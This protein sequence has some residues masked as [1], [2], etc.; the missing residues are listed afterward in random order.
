MTVRPGAA[1]Q[2]R[3]M[4]T[5]AK[6]LRRNREGQMGKRRE[7]FPA[8]LWERLSRRFFRYD[9][10]GASPDRYSALRRNIVILMMAV[11]IVPLTFMAAINHHLYQSGLRNEIVGPVQALVSKTK[12]SFELFMEERLSTIRFIASAYSFAELSDARTINRIFRTLKTEFSG[13]I[14]LGLFDSGGTQVSYAGPYAHFLGRDYSRQDWFQEV[15]VRGAYISDVFTGYREL[16]HVAIAVQ[17]AQEDGRSWILRATIDTDK[18]DA[19]IASMGMDP[20]S[21][22]FLVNRDGILQTPSRFYGK[23]LQRVPFPVPPATPTPTVAEQTDHLEHEILLASVQLGKPDYTLVVVKPRSVV[24]KSWFALKS[25]MLLVFVVSVA[26]ITLVVLKL[27]AVLVRDI[28]EADEKRESAFRELEHNQKL[29]SIGRLAAGVAHEINNP[30]AII[31]EKAGLIKDIVE[32]T[33]DCTTAGDKF[34]ALTGSILQNVQRCRAITHRLL[35]F[36][37]RLDVNVEDLN[38]NEI[39]TEVLGFLEKE[40]VYRKIKI[41]LNLAPEL[42]R[43]SSDRGQLQQ[44]FLNILNNAF[45]AVD[46]GGRVTITTRERDA[47]TLAVSVQDN[48]CGMSEETLRHIFEP[49]FTTKKEYGTGLGLP[50]TYGIVKKLGGDF[51]VESEEGVGTN[52]TVLLKKHPGEQA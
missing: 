12:H 45:A 19:L 6:A 35:G 17:H 33:D 16:P 18:F 15:R 32:R 29:S 52:F 44:V 51:K 5:I 7:M 36:A 10:G 11:T 46:S 8:K 30:L 22:A 42:S 37:K 1:A 2:D 21:D 49:F 13:F 27:S 47:R 23:T 43:I 25:E 31:G 14:D 39:I 26:V 24:L 3:R 48:G 20:G 41:E 38:L 34:L 40:A 4:A 28:R 50:I 9:D